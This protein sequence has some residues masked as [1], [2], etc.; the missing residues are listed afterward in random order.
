LAYAFTTQR[1]S[2]LPLGTQDRLHQP[3]RAPLVKGM[4]QMLDAARGAGANGAAL[5]GAGPSLIA[6][7]ASEGLATKVQSALKATALALKLGGEVKILEFSPR[8]AYVAET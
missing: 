8:G 4:P 1:A 6:F 2:F 3:Y 7:A 5:S